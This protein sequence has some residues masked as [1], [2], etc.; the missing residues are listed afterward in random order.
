MFRPLASKIL[1]LLLSITSYSFAQTLA[2]APK[3]PSSVA[4]L[5][6]VL[7]AAGV[8]SP[9]QV[10]AYSATGEITYFWA[11]KKVTGSVEV[12]GRGPDKFS[13]VASL[14]QGT[15]SWA[16]NGGAGVAKSVPG[17]STSIPYH[18]AVNA[19]SLTLPYSKL[20][21]ALQ[22]TATAVDVGRNLALA[23]NQFIQIRLNSQ[24]GAAFARNPI[25]ITIDPSNLRIV[26]LEDTVSSVNGG[27]ICRRTIY[28][29]DYKLFGGLHAP[30]TIS[31]R[32]AGQ[33]TW[34]MNLATINLAVKA[35]SLEFE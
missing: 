7:A 10:E 19:G 3:D 14:P 2:P 13:L 1:V 20:I 8:Q 18:N 30:S 25:D 15:T 33:R 9:V 27:D 28:Y 21:S 31:E 4:L 29:S 12:S 5:Y 11:G 16:V 6:N 34:M 32:I 24:D 23:G 17:E 35:D 22:D 26:S